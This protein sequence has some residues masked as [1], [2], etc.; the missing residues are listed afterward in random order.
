MENA[1]TEIKDKKSSDSDD[2]L[3]IV[4]DT[5]TGSTLPDNE[6]RTT[7]GY[8]NKAPI[9]LNVVLNNQGQGSDDENSAQSYLHTREA[10][11][12]DDEPLVPR[13]EWI[14]PS[15]YESSDDEERNQH[16]ASSHS[17]YFVNPND[18]NLMQ[19]VEEVLGVVVQPRSCY[20]KVCGIEICNDTFTCFVNPKLV[21]LLLLMIVG[22]VIG[23]I[24][25]I[26]SD[27]NNKLRDNV[28]IAPSI[29]PSL[30]PSLESLEPREKNITALVIGLS[31]DV[32][33]I[34]GTSQ[35]RALNW[36]LYDD[37]MQLNYNSSNIVQRYVMM[38]LFYET[39]GEGWT[40]NTGFGSRTDE[41]TWSGVECSSQDVAAL[42]FGNV[43]IRGKIPIEI[44]YLSQL[45][46]LSL[47]N[48]PGLEGTIPTE[49]GE[50]N[51]LRILRATDNSLIG[52]IPE[53]ISNIKTLGVLR[54]NSNL[55]DGTIPTVLGQMRQ[56]T[57]LFLSDNKFTGTIPSE[58]GNLSVLQNL[59][60]HDNDLKG[61][62][63]SELGNIMFLTNFLAYS[64]RFNGTIPSALGNNA[65]LKDIKLNDNK[66]SGII[67]S[68]LYQ[69]KKLR[70]FDFSMNQL[71]GTIPSFVI[72]S[73]VTERIRVSDT[74]IS[75]TI[76]NS[77][78]NFSR[79]SEMNLHGTRLKGTVPSNICDLRLDELTANC[80]GENPDVVCSCCT[81]CL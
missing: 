48:N 78:G 65:D 33:L 3:E 61:S 10:S 40:K 16:A 44:G 2:S 55:L 47:M 77:F 31:G 13:V 42:L 6:Y 17:E 70:I 72:T 50:L 63:P 45:Q 80:D 60:L 57:H 51:S 64:N 67:P 49:I 71:T 18:V 25:P 74:M 62:I 12:V 53:E 30:A 43:N 38:V 39:N 59:Y 9:N 11:D 54:L 28:L 37:G 8:G 76:P 20:L 1:N 35:N 46:T 26:Q 69:M 73:S 58:L 15:D 36:V 14:Y 4:M 32:A 29:Y 23:I 56:L 5:D 52:S 24:L 66:L 41:C 81:L 34:E 19:E 7:S 79:L 22:I 27:S 75:G 68:K 21:P